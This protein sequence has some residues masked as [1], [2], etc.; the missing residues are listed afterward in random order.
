MPIKVKCAGCD[1]TMTLRAEAAGKKLACPVCKTP[2]YV[3]ES[4]SSSIPAP[5][6]NPEPV[7]IRAKRTGSRVPTINGDGSFVGE[8]VGESHYQKALTA[9]CGGV[10]PDGARH[11]CKA[12][13]IPEDD[14]K[15]DANAIRV[16][17]DGH[18]VGYLCREDAA[19]YRMLM[20]KRVVPRGMVGVEALILGGWD[21]G[22]GDR[23]HFGVR[24]DLDL[25]EMGAEIGLPLRQGRR[26]K[27]SGTQP[28][29]K[30]CGCA[31]L[32]F[33]FLMIGIGHWGEDDPERDAPAHPTVKPLPK[34]A[35]KPAVL[36]PPIAAFLKEHREFGTP[37]AAADL[38]DWASG[39]RQTVRFE[40]GYDLMFYLEG[41]SVRSV[42]STSPRQL[43]WGETGSANP[44][45]PIGRP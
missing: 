23:G 37:I 28:L 25:D 41:D 40:G 19:Y 21:R 6:P 33:I 9:I 20:R 42:W 8:V 36:L 2:F 39:R 29:K 24:I 1:R 32:L 3:P 27:A 10:T 12:Y 43:V 15:F 18:T 45:P 38:P 4:P 22:D 30:G 16:A 7:E 14:N 26:S 13:L 44:D 34:P 11:R 31:T 5:I 35:D 17:I